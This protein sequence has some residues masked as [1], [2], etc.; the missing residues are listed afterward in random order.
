MDVDFRNA[1]IAGSLEEL[2]EMLVV[3]VNTAV[4]DQTEEMKAA[5]GV[6]GVL[7]R[8]FK[9]GNGGELVV[10]DMLV[11]ADNLELRKMGIRIRWELE[12]TEKKS[13]PTS[14]QT[15]RPAP[16]LRWPTSL[17][18][19]RPSGRPTAREE[20]S[21]SVYAASFFRLSMTGVSAPQMASPFW[22]GSGA[23]PQPSITTVRACQ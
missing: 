21:S 23:T 22:L 5:V 20:A 9:V 8:G 16:M 17:L 15:T 13:G 10:L 3:G 6:F 18:P 1:K 14:C 7:K 12:P 19:I 11:D 4:G 2:V